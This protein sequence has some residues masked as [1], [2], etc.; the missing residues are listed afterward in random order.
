MADSF[1]GGKDEAKGTL[2]SKPFTLSRPY[3][4]L[5]VGGGNHPGATCVNLRIGGKIFRTA[6]GRDSETLDWATW[7]VA[8]LHGKEAQIEIVDNESGGWGHILV[9]TIEFADT[10][11]TAAGGAGD[12]KA[13]RDFGTMALA[14]LGVNAVASAG[15]DETQLP[16]SA[17]EASPFGDGHPRFYPEPGRASDRRR[18]PEVCAQTGPVGH[19]DIRGGLAFPE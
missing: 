10:P 4:N 2:T 9:D 5:L 12:V 1:L 18:Q 13:Q 19:A 11:R 15:L 3:I 14:A 17:L 16:A 8:G 7:N 6:T